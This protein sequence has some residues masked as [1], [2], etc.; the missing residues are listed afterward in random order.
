MSASFSCT[1]IGSRIRQESAFRSSLPLSLGVVSLRRLNPG[2]RGSIPPT[3]KSIADRRGAEDEEAAHGALR[4][5]YRETAHAQAPF[6]HWML[7]RGSP[8]DTSRRPQAAGHAQLRL[9]GP[10]HLSALR[11]RFLALNR[12]LPAS[13]RYQGLMDDGALDEHH[14][15]RRRR[16]KETPHRATADH[17]TNES[18]AGRVPMDP[19]YGD[20]NEQHANGQ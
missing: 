10:L 20:R 15:P 9:C 5:M 7:V 6:D 14:A 4:V 18:N 2:S 1:W 17:L 12:K 16:A 19:T 3:A 13:D 11:D 8:L